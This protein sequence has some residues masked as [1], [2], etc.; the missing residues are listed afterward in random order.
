M[1]F[2][3]KGLYDPSTKAFTMQA[4]SSSMIFSIAG[5]LN[6]S[7]SIIPDSSDAT[8]EIKEGSNWKTYDYNITPGNQTISGSANQ[9]AADATPQWS[10][11]TW[12][13]QITGL[14]IVVTENSITVID[15]SD[16]EVTPITIVEITSNSSNAKLLARATLIGT[17]T[18]YTAMFYVA[19]SFD[20]T[21]SSAIGST[22]LGTLTFNSDSTLISAKVGTLPTGTKMFVSPY[23]ST[24]NVITSSPDFVIS[25]FSPMFTTV[26]SAKTAGNSNTNIKAIPTFTLAL[27]H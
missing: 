15:P 22:T 11:G 20:T 16:G 10:R 19:N 13:D 9:P 23:C 18:R 17:N 7:N 14:K 24:T 25:G 4:A 3:L 26:D 6:N 1:I 21:L 8:L 5:K 27:M 2:N 12:Y